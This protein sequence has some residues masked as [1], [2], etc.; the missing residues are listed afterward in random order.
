MFASFAPADDPRF[1]V[2]PSSSS[3]ATAPRSPPRRSSRSTGRC[4]ASTTAQRAGHD[5]LAPR[6]PG[7]TDS[8]APRPDRLMAYTTLPRPAPSVTASVPRR[9]VASP[10]W[11]HVDVAPDRRHCGHL[12][13]GRAHGLLDHPHPAGRGRGQ[14]AGHDEEAGRLRRRRAWSPSS[15]PCFFDYKRYLSWAPAALRGEPAAPPGHPGRGPGRAGRHLV[16]PG[17]EHPGRAVRDREGEPHPV[18]GRP[19]GQPQRRRVGAGCCCWSWACPSCPSCSSTNRTL[20]AAPWCWPS[21]W[22]GCS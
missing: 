3:P 13:P 17:R 16:D 18:A 5:G 15:L 12:G 4:S 1:A 9:P 2:T 19:A 10:A 11:R 6:A 7:R 22:S 14:P 21:S 8:T 20:W